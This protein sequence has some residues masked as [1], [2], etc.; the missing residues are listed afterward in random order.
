M[1]KKIKNIAK[2]VFKI[3]T[4]GNAGVGKTSIIRS[5]LGYSFE[6]NTLSTLGLDFAKKEI[7]LKNKE[8]IHF[9]LI[10][11]SGQEKYKSLSVSYLKHADGVLFVFALNNKLSFEQITDWIELFE[12]EHFG[13]DNIP[14]YLVG[15][16]CDLEKDIKVKEDSIN[17]FLNNKKDMIYFQTSA[18]DN[19]NIE[20][21][22]QEMAEKLYEEYKESGIENKPQ[23]KLDEQ[24]KNKKKRKECCNIKVE[25]D[26]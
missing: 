20:E 1:N 21:V 11:T 13:K 24:P 15:N 22:F 16:K 17:N 19:I 6:T 10:D 14:K 8:K 7:K 9:Q 4:L 3:I 18:K 25:P 5:Y 23:I 12:E 26:I 2:K